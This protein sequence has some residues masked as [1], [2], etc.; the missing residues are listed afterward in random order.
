MLKQTAVQAIEILIEQLASEA[1][2]SSKGPGVQNGALHSTSY[3]GRAAVSEDLAQSEGRRLA[4]AADTCTGP[5]ELACTGT[6]SRH[7]TTSGEAENTVVQCGA[8]AVESEQSH[9]TS[10]EGKDR[11]DSVFGSTGLRTSKSER[12]VMTRTSEEVHCY[13]GEESS[14]SER[15]I[16]SSSAA[17]TPE[18]DSIKRR[19]EQKQEPQIPKQKQIAGLRVAVGKK[20][21]RNR[22]CPCGSKKRYK[23]CC[24]PADAAAARRL[25]SGIVQEP[26]AQG[27][28]APC[29]YV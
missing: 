12:S 23:N 29:I 18:A 21:A 4:D 25:A 10:H 28:A 20:P 3:S 15:E 16:P 1:V 11:A 6:N 14:Q 26:V 7:L 19:S 22:E 2:L 24:G 27:M 5:E 17:G 9:D 13:S 8:D